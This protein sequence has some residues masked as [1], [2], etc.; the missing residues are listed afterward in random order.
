MINLKKYN[1]F[2]G[3][4]N[5]VA[6]GVSDIVNFF[7]LAGHNYLVLTPPRVD[8]VNK[9]V[10]LCLYHYLSN[11]LEFNN[12]DDFREKISEKSNLFRVDLLVFDFWSLNRTELFLYISE[13]QKLNVDFIIVAKEYHYK[14]GDDVNDFLIRTEYKD[15]NRS[16][17]W[18]HDKITGIQS[19]IDSLRLAYIRDKKIEHLFTK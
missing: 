10:E 16:D 1:Y 14:T 9:T 11:K 3:D 2:T 19:T 15:L 8:T 18:L 17:I 4:I 13:I 6:R 7:E 12:F 5:C